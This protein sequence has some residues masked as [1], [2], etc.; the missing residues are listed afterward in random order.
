METE[1]QYRIQDLGFDPREIAAESDPEK[2]LKLLNNDL[3][4]LGL[5]ESERTKHVHRLHPYLGKFIPQLAEVLLT[6]FFKPGDCVLDPF[7][8]SGTAM[9]EANVL[10]MDS[11][12]IELSSFNALISRVK[13]AQYSLEELQSAIEK[14]LSKTLQF[15]ER[16]RN[17]YLP[18]L[19][20]TPEDMSRRVERF[21]TDSL[22]LKTWF[23]DLALQEILSYRKNIDIF[24]D[25]PYIYE[26]LQ[27]LLSR[28]ARSARLVPHHELG[29]SKEP[30]KDMYWCHK[31]YRNCVPATEAIK[32]ILEYSRDSF[33][34][35]K[36]FSSLRKNCSMVVIEGNSGLVCV[37][38]K[39]SG[40][41]TSPPYI[42][43]L[44][45]H[46][47]HRYAYELFNLVS[48]SSSEIGSASRGINKTAINN[49]CLDMIKVFKHLSVWLDSGAPVIIIANDNYAVYPGIGKESGLILQDT[50]RR[51]VLKR[52]AR[53]NQTY[54]ESIFYFV[55]E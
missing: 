22:Y 49:Y 29:R 18:V 55:K 20:D 36:E 40:I 43:V 2:N 7:V 46:E 48:R 30:I 19:S 5:T 24:I 12:G 1:S 32:F 9:I 42:G 54:Y 45:Y 16:L 53:A 41:L 21:S 28:V 26:F 38:R 39:V 47:Q 52:T 17:E 14:V 8:G 4:F 34:R 31:H 10:G 6:R 13:T 25:S 44:D 15:S 33:E 23:A 50:F 3:I 35:I 51:P 27:V 11:I 37:G